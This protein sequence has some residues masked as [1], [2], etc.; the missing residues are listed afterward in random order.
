MGGVGGSTV[1]M[2]YADGTI[3]TV[4]MVNIETS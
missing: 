3:T 2:K 4:I 1:H